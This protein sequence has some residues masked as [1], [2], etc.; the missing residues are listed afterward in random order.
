V[1]KKAVVPQVI[2]GIAGQNIKRRAPE[3]LFQI[4]FRITAGL[5]DEICYID[6]S[7]AVIAAHAV[8]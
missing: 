6:V 4:G 7:V 8:P 5:K 3:K 1:Q 2:V